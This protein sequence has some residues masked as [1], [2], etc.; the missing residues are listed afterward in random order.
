VFAAATTSATELVDVLVLLLAEGRDSLY[1][2]EE[3]RNPRGLLF[4]ASLH[5]LR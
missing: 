2:Q 5:R 3:C 4:V 1:G